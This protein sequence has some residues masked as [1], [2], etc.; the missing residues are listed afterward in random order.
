MAG[1]QRP[2]LGAA[3]VA[4]W[5][6][7]PASRPARPRGAERTSIRDALY[8]RRARAG[9]RALTVA[10][11]APRLAGDCRRCVGLTPRPA[12]AARMSTDTRATMQRIVVLNPKGGSGKTTI[13]INLAS[14]FAVQRHA[15]RA[16]GLRSAGLLHA[17]GEEA[18][19]R[20]SRR[21]TSS[22]PSRRTPHHAQLPAARAGGRARTSSW[23]RP[24]R[25][26]A[27][28][29]A[30]ADARCATRSSCRCCPRTSTSTPARAA[31]ATCCWSPRSSREENRIGVI[32]NRVRRNTLIYQ[33]LIRFLQTLGIPIVATIRD[34]QNY[35]RAAELG[36]GMHEMKSYV[37][38][39]DV[40][41]WQP[42]MDWLEPP[43]ARRAARPRQP[44]NPAAPPVTAERRRLSSMRPAR[45][46]RLACSLTR[47][48]RGGDRGLDRLLRRSDSSP[49]I[50]HLVGPVLVVRPGVEILGDRRVARTGALHAIE[51]ARVRRPRR[52]AAPADRASS[53]WRC[54]SARSSRPLSV[55]LMEAP[56][57]QCSVRR[58]AVA[59]QELVHRHVAQPHT[60]R[61]RSRDNSSRCAATRGVM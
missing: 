1:R 54:S 26:R 29:T 51:P 2:A 31:S 25:C 59:P 27:A 9:V 36:I 8:G 5:R 45:L 13:A 38:Q 42:L 17:L 23:T 61:R 43:R 52:P 28:G 44:S 11:V 56:E 10:H 50:A 33:S 21:F 22:P 20:R 4:T 41:Q 16:D 37:A 47:R 48:S 60:L 7:A 32:A 55:E 53:R 15:T 3:E 39:E 46:T 35:V 40:E 58:L 34:S 12:S 6:Q 18:H 19:S 30:R 57:I 24:R 14:Y 49:R